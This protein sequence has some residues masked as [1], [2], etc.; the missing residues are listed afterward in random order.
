MRKAISAVLVLAALSAILSV[1]LVALATAA[2][3]KNCLKLHYKSLP[4]VIVSGRITTHHKLP[5][6]S[7][8]RTGDG[9]W[10]IL[11]EPLLADHT[12]F[13]L[14]ES[15]YKLCYKW[16]KIAI[17]PG[18]DDWKE[19][20]AQITQIKKWNN[21]H[22]TIDGELDHFASGLVSPNVYIRITTIK[23]D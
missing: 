14:G 11:D 1:L 8:G 3:A 6:D 22:V 2:H 23:K 20:E 10:L 12:E 16:R 18:G 15:P 4:L 13:A 9:P 19:A 21:Q 7:E 5:E 17:L